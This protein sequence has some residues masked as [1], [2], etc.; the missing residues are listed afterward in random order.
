MGWWVVCFPLSSLVCVFLQ[1]I[2]GIR[3][4]GLLIT[5]TADL[6]CVCSACF[7]QERSYRASA[8]PASVSLWGCD[9]SLEE[10]PKRWGGCGL[11]SSL[12]WLTS[13]VVTASFLFKGGAV[14]DS[15]EAGVLLRV[16][17]GVKCL[18]YSPGVAGPSP[19]LWW[20]WG[21]TAQ[22]CLWN[23]AWAFASGSGYLYVC[24]PRA[25]RPPPQ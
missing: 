21:R 9:H 18:H 7:Q 2:N 11:G 25:P 16:S 15:R 10:P 5:F 8:F 6:L 4:L 24:F 17:G 23:C 19:S 20:C 3:L 13:S 22:P 12:A 1:P 14:E